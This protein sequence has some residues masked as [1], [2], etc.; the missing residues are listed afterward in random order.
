MP[1]AIASAT[2]SNTHARTHTRTHAA[3]QMRRG[4]DALASLERDQFHP[5]LVRV[6]VAVRN[7]L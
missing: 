6:R 4:F 5:V 2:L 3:R 7:M 1:C